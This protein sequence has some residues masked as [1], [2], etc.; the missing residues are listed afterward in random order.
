MTDRN[1]YTKIRG[2]T[3]SQF[4]HKSVS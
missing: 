2:T 3:F 4:Y 1:I